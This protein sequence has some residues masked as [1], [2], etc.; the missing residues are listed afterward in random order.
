MPRC[1]AKIK[2]LPHCGV[3]ITTDPVFARVFGSEEY[4]RVKPYILRPCRSRHF[5]HAP[6][7]ARNPILVKSA[8]IGI[9]SMSVYLLIK[10]DEFHYLEELDSWHFHD[11]S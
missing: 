7:T 9:M 11:K 3:F 5:R 2:P 8:Q 4:A 6:G 10:D 1:T